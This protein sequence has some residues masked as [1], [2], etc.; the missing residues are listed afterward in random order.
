MPPIEHRTTELE[1][2][3]ELLAAVGESPISSVTGDFPAG[4]QMAIDRLRSTSR[5]VQA[6]GWHFNTEYD[7]L[8][9]R[10]GATNKVA[11]GL[12][13]L[14]ADLT[15]EMANVDVTQRGAF[16]YNKHDQ[17][18]V[19]SFN[20]RLTLKYYLTWD[21]LPEYARDYIKTKAARI[22]QD[23]TV[24]S[25]DHHTFTQQDEIEAYSL[26]K[27]NDDE[28]EDANIFDSWD[29]GSIVRRR[30]PYPSSF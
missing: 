22:F 28:N 20:P 25:G 11:L 12:N 29:V 30:R 19:F 1:A 18:F 7:V 27:S 26:M 15:T 2:V 10:D 3:N 21:E 8:H 4:I 6:K 24:G 5:K 16:L 23:Q 17:T 14:D 13:V 9:S